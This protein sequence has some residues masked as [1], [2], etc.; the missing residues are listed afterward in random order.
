MEC[1]EGIREWIKLRSCGSIEWWVPTD[2]AWTCWSLWWSSDTPF[3]RIF[4]DCCIRHRTGCFGASCV[5]KLHVLLLVRMYLQICNF[6]TIKPYRKKACPTWICINRACVPYSWVG[7]FVVSIRLLALDGT[8]LRLAAHFSEPYH[9][10][11]VVLYV[12]FDQKNQRRRA[13]SHE[14]LP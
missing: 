7:L 13:A 12:M 11:N 5:R 4:V 9:T 3:K 10:D 8:R 1:R 6:C 14:Q 2:L